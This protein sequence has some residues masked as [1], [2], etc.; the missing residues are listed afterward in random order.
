MAA[1]WPRNGQT[2]AHSSRLFPE[3]GYVVAEREG[4]GGHT[5]R[6]VSEPQT[7]NGRRPATLPTWPKKSVQAF[8]QQHHHAER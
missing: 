3:R 6:Y 7:L 2:V 4:A 8:D 1:T 5:Q